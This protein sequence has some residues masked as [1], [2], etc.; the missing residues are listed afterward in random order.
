MSLNKGQNIIKYCVIISTAA[1]VFIAMNT[2]FIAKKSTKNVNNINIKLKNL[3]SNL[4]SLKKEIN[5]V[6]IDLVPSKKQT[7]RW[8]KC[9]KNIVLWFNKKGKNLWS[10]YKETKESLT[11]PVRNVAVYEATPKMK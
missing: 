3:S 4:D 8:N 9:F 10:F 2:I 5:N 11:V 6:S 1:L 7:Q